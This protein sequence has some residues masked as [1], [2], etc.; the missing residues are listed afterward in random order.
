MLRHLQSLPADHLPRM[1]S[2][3]LNSILS[4]SR[5]L[6]DELNAR[7]CQSVGNQLGYLISKHDSPSLI[8]SKMRGAFPSD[9][10]EYNRDLKTRCESV[11]EYPVTNY[12]PQLHALHYEWYF[13]AAAALE[14]SREF[15]SDQTVAVCIG[16][17]TVASAAIKQGKNVIFVDKNAHSLMRFPDLMRAS[18]VHIMDALQGK[19]L[20]LKSDV[21]IFDAPWYVADIL[22]WL[23]VASRVV[24]P[25]GMIVFALFPPLVRATA[26]LERDLILDLA[27]AVG[28]VDVIED[29][30]AY[31]TPLFEHEALK[32]CRVHIGDWRYGDL[33]VIKGAKPI[34]SAFPAAPRRVDVD[35]AWQTFVI[36][37]QVVKLRNATTERSYSF[38][39]PVADSFLFPAVSARN[40]SRE[41]IHVWS[42]KNRVASVGDSQ[43]L[44]EILD[45]LAE[46]DCLDSVV[47][48]YENRFGKQIGSQL[49]AFLGLES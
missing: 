3:A 30:L 46:G 25:G 22:A 6:A 32:A 16:V 4:P 2:T 15:L 20:N 36:G 39:T 34:A 35:G 29:A 14:V 8:L 43:A 10:V 44:S 45:R 17:P 7:Y 12:A 1:Y 24:R 42:S 47:R 19:R 28:R 23:E 31:E 48:G 41:R 33:V 26:T 37:P 27:S 18:E 49:G 40:G 21:I 5:V 9:V 13:T 38:L 11:S